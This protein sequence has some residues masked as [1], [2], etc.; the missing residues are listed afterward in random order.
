MER[1]KIITTCGFCG[2]GCNLEIEVENGRIHS[3]KGYEHAIVN[4]GESCIKGSQGWGYV[5]SD[6]R[7]TEP[8][9]KKNGQFVPATWDEA[10]DLIA[11]KF[12]TLKEENGSDALG[13]F[14]SSRQTNELNYLAQK[15]MRTVLGN[16]NIDSCART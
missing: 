5:H 11:E 14:T 16:S 3:V 4:Q 1:E 12:S 6:K 15:F 2:V 9:I 10:L 8:L 13:C 7:L